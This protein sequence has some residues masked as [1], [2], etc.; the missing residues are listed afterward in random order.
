MANT[1]AQAQDGYFDS[2]FGPGG[3]LLVDVSP[4][5]KDAGKVLDIQ[6]DGK[7]LLAGTC[8]KL[9]QIHQSMTTATGHWKSMDGTSWA[10]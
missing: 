3:H 1:A 6:P 4:D 10:T 9:E 2:S 7:L 8:G 5:S